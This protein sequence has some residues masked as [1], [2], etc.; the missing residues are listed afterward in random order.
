[1]ED[2]TLDGQKFS[3][4]LAEGEVQVDYKRSDTWHM[5][6]K[7]LISHGRPNVRHDKWKSK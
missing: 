3:K 1:M 7:A 2:Q 4:E 5:W 6:I